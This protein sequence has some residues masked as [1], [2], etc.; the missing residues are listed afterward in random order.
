MFIYVSRCLLCS[1]FSV[2]YTYCIIYIQYSVTSE[3]L[4]P[5]MTGLMVANSEEAVQVELHPLPCFRLE[6]GHKRKSN[7]PHI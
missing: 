1:T 2:I 6:P 5:V 3:D 7:F 4:I